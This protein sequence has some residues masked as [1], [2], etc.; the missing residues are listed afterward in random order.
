MFLIAGLGKE[1]FWLINGWLCILFWWKQ[2]NS[3][4]LAGAILQ[5]GIF[6]LLFLWW[7]PVHSNLEGY[8][9]LAFIGAPL[10]SG[11]NELLQ[12]MFHNVFSLRSVL[13]MGIAILLSGG[14]CIAGANLPLWGAAPGL[15]MI[16][17]T[18]SSQ[19]HHPG[20]HYLIPVI[21]FLFVA[22]MVNLDRWRDHFGKYAS[23]IALLI[24]SIGVVYTTTLPGGVIDKISQVHQV[25]QSQPERRSSVQKFIAHYV[26]SDAM[27]VTDGLYQPIASPQHQ[28]TTVLLSFIGNPHRLDLSKLVAPFYVYTDASIL[29]LPNCSDVRIGAR[30]LDADYEYFAKLC[31]YIKLYGREL[32]TAPNG[33]KGYLIT[34]PTQFNF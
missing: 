19:V 20:N 13:T 24:A 27:L 32:F 4:W 23:V 12:A 18:S 21:P 17:V 7:M 8:Y 2:R 14:I 16:L 5:V 3:I 9:G 29:D 28:P 25:R 33:A 1:N 22:G 11:W 10:G 15:A 31:E 26:E 34:P 30:N 6:A